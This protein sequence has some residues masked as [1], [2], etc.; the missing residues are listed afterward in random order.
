MPL[1]WPTNI[2]QHKLGEQLY[3]QTKTEKFWFITKP[4]EQ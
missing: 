2:S 1:V 3:V 4:A